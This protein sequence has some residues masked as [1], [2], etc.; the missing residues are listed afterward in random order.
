MLEEK[1]LEHNEIF[2][3]THQLGSKYNWDYLRHRLELSFDSMLMDDR[4]D[5]FR[6]RQSM[7]ITSVLVL[8]ACRVSE[9]LALNLGSINFENASDG[10]RWINI[11]LPNIKRKKGNKQI[12]RIPILIDE[13]SEFY[14]LI[15]VL[16]YYIEEVIE[17][18]EIMVLNNKLEKHNVLDVPVFTISRH[19]YYLDCKKYYKI[20]P[21]GIRKIMTQYLVVEN[22]IPIKVVQKILG[23]SDLKNLD[24]Y[25]N[26]RNEDI[27][28]AIIQNKKHKEMN[29]KW[30]MKKLKM[31]MLNI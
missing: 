25:M 11:T 18:L 23:H 26:L 20:N 30:N 5:P 22:N 28:N 21:H 2:V 16:E 1:D 19:S 9:A 12:K 4:Y 6:K 29:K 24:F 3:Y 13:N 14:F 10:N 31:I 15:K 17:G 7:A 8:T 27:K